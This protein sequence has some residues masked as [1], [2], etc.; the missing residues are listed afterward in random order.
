MVDATDIF[1][2]KYESFEEIGQGG[3]ATVYRA[4]DIT[5]KRAVAIKVLDARLSTSESTTTKRFA[6]EAQT[7]ARLSHPHIIDVYET[8]QKQG[9][10]FIVMPYLPG[11][12]L[13]KLIRQQGALPLD[14]VLRFS[15]Q[16]G[17]ALDYAHKNGLIHRDI[18]P[19]NVILNEHGDA[20][21]TDFGIVKVIDATTDLTQTGA[22]M[23]T[24][25]YMAPEQW[26]ASQVDARTDLYALGVMVYQM[27]TG[28][29]PFT[30]DTPHRIMYGHLSET[31]P[32][33]EK[34]NPTLSPAV[35]RVLLKMLSKA[36]AQ[37]YQTAAEFCADLRRALLDQTVVS[38]PPQKKSGGNSRLALIGGAA[39]LVVLL[40]AAV[41]GGILWFSGREATTPAAAPLVREAVVEIDGQPVADNFQQVVCNTARRLEIKFLDADGQPIDAVDFSY[42]WRFEPDDPF[43]EDKANSS[44]YATNYQVPCELDNQ[45]VTIEARKDGKTFF[46][47]SLLFDI[48]Q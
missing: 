27:L 43:N 28:Q 19:A 5:L 20:I 48:S 45:T 40:L 3:F 21:L 37:R 25:Y 11:P 14:Q 32:P 15:E 17:G 23:G 42:N 1:A 24:P 35:G 29:M 46:T 12:A 4:T 16:I 33:P 41:G 31:P 13:D 38:Q 30:G 10:F 39:L 26:T 7:V 22:S 34:L 18:K 9:R 6:R 44:N 47:K 8:G 2:D 36:P